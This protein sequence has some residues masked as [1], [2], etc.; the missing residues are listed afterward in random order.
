MYK[1]F[2]LKIRNDFII[3]FLLRI[4]Y[5]SSLAVMDFGGERKYVTAKEK[6][7]LN[8]DEAISFFLP[9]VQQILLFNQL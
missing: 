3:L 6:L 5:A 7:I 4:L 2:F 8:S 9:F 1:G